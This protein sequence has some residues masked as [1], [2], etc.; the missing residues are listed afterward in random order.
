MP[1]HP[2]KAL[3]TIVSVALLLSSAAEAAKKR[4]ERPHVAASHAARSVNATAYRT[5]ASP[6]L[7][8]FG[9]RVIGT[10]PD[11]RIRHELLRDLGAVFGGTD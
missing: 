5:A 10:D 4:N 2:I 11:P 8:V 7:V 9:G 1:A 3:L 6:P